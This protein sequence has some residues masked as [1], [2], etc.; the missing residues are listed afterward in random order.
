MKNFLILSLIFAIFCNVKSQAQTEFKHIIFNKGYTFTT[1]LNKDFSFTQSLIMTY[2]GDYNTLN[3][4][5][6]LTKN[7]NRFWSLSGG[8]QLSTI[9]QSNNREL[10]IKTFDAL[11]INGSFGAEYSF[12]NST[13]SYFSI[14]P[15]LI[16]IDGSPNAPIIKT[17]PLN[18]NFGIKF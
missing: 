10:P 11:D 6:I 1:Y 16:K 3:I 13:T 5:I 7:I 14:Q 4:P 8:I 2:S 15:Q 9:Y 18:F 12:R 17:Q